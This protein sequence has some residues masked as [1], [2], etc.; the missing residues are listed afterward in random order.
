MRN[1]INF[2]IRYSAW[3]FF[4]IYVL[5][6]CLL[7][8]SDGGYHESLYLSSANAVSAK[9]TGTASD[10]SEYFNLRDVNRNL[11]ARN[12]ALENKVLNLENQLAHYAALAED[13]GRV[14]PADI[15]FSYVP[16]YVINNS[17]RHPRNYFTINRGSLDGVESGM[18]VVDFNG[19]AGIV[20]VTGDHTSRVVSLLHR[21]QKFSAKLKDTDYTGSVAWKGDSPNVAYLEEVPRHAVYHIGDTVVTSGY[22]NTFPSGIPVGIVTGRVNGSD[23]NYM[24]LRMKLAVNF[25]RLNSVRVIR[26]NLKSELDSLRKKD[27]IN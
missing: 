5:I 19:I 4:M 14:T 13:S 16:A 26:D 6:S 20:N 21:D 11:Q 3:F 23:D 2:L 24:T 27:V 25:N 7:L 18:G 1:L 22:S 8:F 9:I 15:R 17:T 12:A 10:W